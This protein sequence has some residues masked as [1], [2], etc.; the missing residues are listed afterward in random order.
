MLSTPV[1]RFV[2]FFDPVNGQLYLLFVHRH[3]GEGSLE[4]LKEAFLD[5]LLI[6]FIRSFV[7]SVTLAKGKETLCPHEL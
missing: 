7:G 3:Q 2:G 1:L 5:P 6:I 4:G